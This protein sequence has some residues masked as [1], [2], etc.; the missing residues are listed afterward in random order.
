[1]LLMLLGAFFVVPTSS[2]QLEVGT[3]ASNRGKAPPTGKALHV[4]LECA[5]A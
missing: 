3:F 2:M 1:M 4:E 5:A